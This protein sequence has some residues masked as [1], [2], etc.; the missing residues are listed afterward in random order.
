[1]CVALGLTAPKLMAQD[2]MIV[3]LS[4]SIS[5]FRF[6][7]LNG[8]DLIVPSGKNMGHMGILG[9][10]QLPTWSP[11]YIIP[12]WKKVASVE[13]VSLDSIQISGNW[14]IYPAQDPEDTAWIFPDSAIYGSDSLYPGKLKDNHFHAAFDGARVT[15]LSLYPMGYRPLS[16]R[17]FLYTN[18][19]LRLVFKDSDP[20]LNALQ[21]YAHIQEIYDRLLADLVE[22]DAD[23]GA[24]YRRPAMIDPN[25]EKTQILPA[26]I[27]I[28]TPAHEQHLQPYADWMW[29]KGYP[30]GTSYVS[31]FMDDYPFEPDSA[32]KMRAFMADKYHDW[33][34][35]F[36]LFL[37]T[38]DEVPFRYLGPHIYTS[39]PGK[40]ESLTVYIPSDL[41]FSDVDLV[42]DK[43]PDGH[44][45]AHGYEPYNP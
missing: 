18:A 30:T 43:Q 39:I 6:D 3:R 2:T 9:R 25:G 11:P 8:Y 12:W 27:V 37:G 1:M 15:T 10:P 28:T 5:D 17:L 33:G 20:P 4:V 44:H 19:T 35:S 29:Q 31:D 41:Y 22:N 42:W 34:T 23:I 36:F 26:F 14:N 16:G 40:P 45:G 13:V 7:T 38:E 24:W 21:R 32:A